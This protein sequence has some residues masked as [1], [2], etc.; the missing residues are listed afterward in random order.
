MI[1]PDLTIVLIELTSEEAGIIHELAI[2]RTP[3]GGIFRM[4]C[5]KEIKVYEEQPSIKGGKPED[6]TCTGCKQARAPKGV[7]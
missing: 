3:E 6:V 7:V 4:A 1:N 5:G 2:D